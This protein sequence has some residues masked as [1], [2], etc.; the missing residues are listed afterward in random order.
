MKNLGT[1]GNVTTYQLEESDVPKIPMQLNSQEDYLRCKI[2]KKADHEGQFCRCEDRNVRIAKEQRARGESAWKSE[3]PCNV[4]D[5]PNLTKPHLKCARTPNC[6]NPPKLVY[7]DPGPSKMSP[8][9]KEKHKLAHE[10]IQK[11]SV[12]IVNK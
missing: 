4:C 9:M 8:S 2:C 3:W 1:K 12:P 6:T 10:S 11:N 7:K 5:T